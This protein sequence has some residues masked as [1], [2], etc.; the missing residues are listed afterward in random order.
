[1]KKIFIYI[2]ALLS[3]NARAQYKRPFIEMISSEPI[4]TLT[5]SDTFT[6]STGRWY[7][8]FGDIKPLLGG[9]YYY[10]HDT[11]F[12]LI[13]NSTFTLKKE[14]EEVYSVINPIYTPSDTL[15]SGYKFF[16]GLLYYPNGKIKQSGEQNESGRRDGVWNYF[17]ST[18]TMKKHQLFRDGILIDDDFYEWRDD[19]G[20]FSIDTPTKNPLM[21]IWVAEKNIILNFYT[22]SFK[23]SR[24]AMRGDVFQTPLLYGGIYGEA[25]DTV[26]LKSN[27]GISKF[28]KESWENYSLITPLYLKK[29]DTLKPNENK[30]SVTLYYP[31]GNVKQE[32][33]WING[34]KDYLLEYYD[35]TDTHIPPIPIKKQLFRDGVLVD[36]N[37]K[38]DWEK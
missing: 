16:V 28:K 38:W 11:L 14:T 29:N 22:D 7:G 10:H 2:F 31:N 26:I 6:L 3:F 13:K 1:M 25:H 36:D 21:R 12:L 30:I 33:N 34:R 37:F 9:K 20:I 8:H 32:G 17:D 18:G 15:G 23:I 19:W 35:S 5:L 27:H 24:V 4:M